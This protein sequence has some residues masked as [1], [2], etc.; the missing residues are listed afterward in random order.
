MIALV[1]SCI[2]SFIEKLRKKEFRNHQ[3]LF[4]NKWKLFFNVFIKGSL[5]AR[6]LNSIKNKLTY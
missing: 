3:G 1:F 2:S 5:I 6:N 4:K